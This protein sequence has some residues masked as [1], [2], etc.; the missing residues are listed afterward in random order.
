MVAMTDRSEP[1][2]ANDSDLTG[3]TFT[4]CVLKGVAFE[5]VA[6]PSAR[7]RNINLADAAMQEMNLSRASFTAGM[8]PETRFTDVNL[9]GATFDNVDLSDAA[10]RDA[11]LS[12]VRIS[13]CTLDRMRIDGIL[14]TDLLVVYRKNV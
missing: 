12:G 13:G 14:V 10:V 9:A 11:N 6:M 5:D 3:S 8:L 4:R 7:F 1:I 2:A